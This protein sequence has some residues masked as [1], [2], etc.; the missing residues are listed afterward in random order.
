[1]VS[2]DNLNGLLAVLAGMIIFKG[3]T[4]LD[5]I[6]NIFKEYTTIAIIIGFVLFFYRKKITDKI[7][8]GKKK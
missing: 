6:E 7:L 1:M 5:Y 8:G 2:K 3:T 4:Y